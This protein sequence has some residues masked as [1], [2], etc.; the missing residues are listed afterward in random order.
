M[1]VLSMAEGLRDYPQIV[2]GEQEAS[3]I[4][5]GKVF[6]K[7]YL[8]LQGL[9]EPWVFTDHLGNLLAVYKEHKGGT[10][11]PD[12]VIPSDN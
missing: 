4:R 1:C 2:V 9:P 11:K 12:V 8:D 5:V 7:D 3:L 10:I 6:E